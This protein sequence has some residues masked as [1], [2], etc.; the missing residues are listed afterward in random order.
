MLVGSAFAPQGQPVRS[1]LA[2]LGVGEID[3]TIEVHLDRVLSPEGV[4]VEGTPFAR[5]SLSYERAA[6]GLET[7]NPIGVRADARDAYGRTKLPNLQPPGFAIGGASA[8]LPPVGFGPVPPTWPQRWGKL[9]R[10]ASSWAPGWLQAAPLPEDLDRGF[11]NAAP[12]DQQLAELPRRRGSCSRTCTRRS[13][14]SSPS[15]P[16]CGRAPRSRG[17]AVTTR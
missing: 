2:R 6:G 13:R 12:A 7:A 14:G 9:G 8:P 17:A 5:M 10:H 3:K 4:R 16:R 11:F 15:S 1:L